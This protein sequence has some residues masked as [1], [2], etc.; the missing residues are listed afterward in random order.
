MAVGLKPY[1]R[2]SRACLTAQRC[3]SAAPKPFFYQD[4]VTQEKPLD[5]PFKKLTGS[6][7]VNVLII[8]EITIF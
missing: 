8:S 2:F 4:L 6:Y 7:L 3:M 5:I 1:M